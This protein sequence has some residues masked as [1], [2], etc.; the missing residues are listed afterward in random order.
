MLKMISR[1]DVRGFYSVADTVKR[2]QLQTVA[3]RISASGDGHY[4]VLLAVMLLLF[5]S[6]GQQLFNLL[7]TS[8]AIELPLYVLLKNSIRRT[9]PCY[10]FQGI[11]LGFEPSDKFSLPSGHTAAA[12]VMAT[13]TCFVLPILGAVLLVWALL[14]GLS[15]VALMVHYPTDIIAGALLGSGSVM[16]ALNYIS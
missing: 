5:H 14:I 4:Y 2:Y 7:L 15:R 6:K 10:C 1:F 13:A 16:L 8:F 3:K 12:T 9:R 11:E